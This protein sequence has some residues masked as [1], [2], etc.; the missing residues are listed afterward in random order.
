MGTHGKIVDV[1]HNLYFVPKGPHNYAL[2]VE[3]SLKYGAR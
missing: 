2:N 3:I 1:I